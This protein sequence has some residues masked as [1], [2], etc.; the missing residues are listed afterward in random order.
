[1]EKLIPNDQ[2]LVHVQENDKLA[3]VL[4]VIRES[5]VSAVPIMGTKFSISLTDVGQMLVK[6]NFDQ[7][8]ALKTYA[9]EA[10]QGHTTSLN[11]AVL[12]DAPLGSVVD[13]ILASHSY[14]I[15]ILVN[16]HADYPT[17]GIVSQLDLVRFIYEH[18]NTFLPG[19][20]KQPLNK[21]TGLGSPNCSTISLEKNS[22]VGFGFPLF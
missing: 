12:G 14:R 5:H 20:I 7:D 10:V 2:K 21:I 4:R 16:D 15:H 13:F 9:R 22:F 3:D 17:K 6:A 18:R 1:M 19:I 11:Q 8:A